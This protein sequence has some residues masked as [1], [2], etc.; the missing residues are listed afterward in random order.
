MDRYGGD[1]YR[2]QM[3]RYGG[4]YQ[5]WGSIPRYDR[6]FG[7]PNRSGRFYDRDLS[8][9]EQGGYGYRSAPRY[10]RGY[11]DR[12][13]G[14]YGQQRYGQPYNQPA[15]QSYRYGMRDSRS[16]PSPW[17][18]SGPGHYRFGLGYGQ[19]RGQFIYK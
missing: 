11:M 13:R 5:Q 3:M 4:E 9:Y 10:D 19:G 18:E 15:D 14:F 1:F 17:D 16:Y 2:R 7:Y 6:E 8:G 12:G